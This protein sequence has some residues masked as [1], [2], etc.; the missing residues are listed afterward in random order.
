MDKSR[1]ERLG[2]VRLNT[3]LPP[4]ANKDE[5]PVRVSQYRSAQRYDPVRPTYRLSPRGNPI[6]D[7][8]D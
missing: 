3:V 1:N 2:K 5:K 8:E 7:H 6:I 4:T